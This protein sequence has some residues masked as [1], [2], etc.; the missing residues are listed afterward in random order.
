MSRRV[1]AG[2]EGQAMRERTKVRR[3]LVS[4]LVAVA[5]FANAAEGW[6]Q[7]SSVF[8]VVRQLHCVF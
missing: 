6:G 7:V 8:V 2:E 1:E 5:I 4:I 3:F